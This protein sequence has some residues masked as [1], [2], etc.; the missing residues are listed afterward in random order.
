[1]KLKYLNLL[2]AV[3]VWWSI[4]AQ[5]GVK[6]L[7]EQPLTEP[8]YLQNV[9]KEAEKAKMEICSAG[10]ERELDLAYVGFLDQIKNWF[11]PYGG[12]ENG[13]SVVDSIKKQITIHN[14]SLVVDM[15]LVDKIQVGSDSF[16][17][18]DKNKC[19]LVSHAPD[20]VEVL[21]E[22]VE[23]YTEVHKLYAAPERISTLR[24]LE[25]LRVEWEPFLDQMKGQTGLEL[26]I[27][28]AA[29]RND[30]DTFSAP[31]SSQWIVLHPT[32]LVENVSAA[33]G[34]EKIKEALGLEIIGMNWWKQDK[35]YV[36]SGASALA[37]YSDRS[38]FQSLGYGAA[39]HFL[40]DYTV[41]YTNHDG[42]DGFFVSV[43]LIKLFQNKNNVYESYKSAFD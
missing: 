1:M 31:P 8:S 16:Q 37:V 2:A 11:N 43:D 26:L 19:V 25:K 10:T 22:F 28:R 34:G 40:S 33:A 41:G 3:A 42:E 6:M 17:P 30:S 27:N 12:F 7:C 32:L 39:I 18:H 14:R 20:C 23:L 35:W 4:P 9:G 29:Y 13:G 24:H 36:P 5:S 38:G 21:Q 15:N